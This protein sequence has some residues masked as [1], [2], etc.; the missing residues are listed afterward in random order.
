MEIPTRNTIFLQGIFFDKV[1]TIEDR[2]ISESQ[3]EADQDADSSHLLNQ[4]VII[5]SRFKNIKLW[6]EATKNLQLRCW[7]CN[8][9]FMGIPCFIPKQVRNTQLGKE[10]DTSGWFCG[11]ACAYAYL[12]STAEYRIN[13]TFF[14]KLSM[15]KMLFTKFYNKKVS[16]FYEAPNK[17]NLTTYGGYLDMA[18][19]K[20]QLKQCNQKIIS[21]ATNVPKI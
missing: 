3:D 20:V 17:Y 12:C 13:K 10:F 2:M 14:D 6:K 5:P 8:L 11:F 15:M 1:K 9:T 16:E 18:D 19:Y 4:C 21:D 7:Y